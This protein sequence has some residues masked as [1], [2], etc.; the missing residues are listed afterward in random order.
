[1]GKEAKMSAL[2]VYFRG[3]PLSCRVWGAGG[4]ERGEKEKFQQLIPLG[5]NFTSPKRFFYAVRRRKRGKSKR[6]KTGK[7]G[8]NE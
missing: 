8:P 3:G 1:M 7:D 2:A 6:K 5:G 4:T